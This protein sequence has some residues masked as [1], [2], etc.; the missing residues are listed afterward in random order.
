[1]EL[2]KCLQEVDRNLLL[3][4]FY[5]GLSNAEIA[6]ALGMSEANVKKRYQR[7]K[8]RLM[9]RLIEQEGDEIDE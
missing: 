3:L 4:K 8:I 1:M 6:E 5:V 9:S 7:I 2:L